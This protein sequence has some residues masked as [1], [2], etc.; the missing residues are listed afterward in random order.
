LTVANL[1]VIVSLFYRIFR[2][3][4]DIEGAEPPIAR[5]SRSPV[6]ESEGTNGLARETSIGQV[7]MLD[8][9][10]R[11]LSFT[12]TRFSQLIWSSMQVSEPPCLLS[13]NMSAYWC[14]TYRYGRNS[15]SNLWDKFVVK[16]IHLLLLGSIDRVQQLLSTQCPIVEANSRRGGWVG[17]NFQWL[18]DGNQDKEWLREV[19]R[20]KIKT[21]QDWTNQEERSGI[22]ESL[23]V[24]CWTEARLNSRRNRGRFHISCGRSEHWHKYYI[25]IKTHT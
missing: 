17:S 23:R 21:L 3:T 9:E 4:R 11:P 7:S 24:A 2:Q 25:L 22:K 16:S 10:D 1:L 14:S 6:M 13:E 5:K 15:L 19:S 12:L 8:T 20:Q 18:E